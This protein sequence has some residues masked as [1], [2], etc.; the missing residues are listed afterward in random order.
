VTGARLSLPLSVSAS[1]KSFANSG[2]A[3]DESYPYEQRRI[4]RA[5]NGYGKSLG[6][7]CDTP[8][9]A[10]LYRVQIKAAIGRFSCMPIGRRVE[11]M[12]TIKIAGPPR[13]LYQSRWR[14]MCASY[15]NR[16]ADATNDG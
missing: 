12:Y 9:F 8:A 2:V 4:S 13:I 11:D 1:R 14:F 10:T 5:W 7:K 6:W 3:E 16:E 15:T